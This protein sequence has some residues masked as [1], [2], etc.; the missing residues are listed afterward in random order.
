MIIPSQIG[1][2][3]Y[4]TVYTA[5]QWKIVCIAKVMHPHL[6]WANQK[7]ANLEPILREIT[8]LSSL[9]HPSIV[10]LLGVHMK[11]ESP[12]PITVMEKSWK[13]LSSVLEE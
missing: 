8:T 6:I 12:V 5:L 2:G 9:R 3:S 11:D 7:H 1:S 13:S 4:G 10:Q